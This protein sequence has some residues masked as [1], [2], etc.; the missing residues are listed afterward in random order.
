[1]A[2]AEETAELSAAFDAQER[3]LDVALE[4]SGLVNLDALA[5]D[6]V[7]AYPA[8]NDKA[9]DFNE[10]RDVAVPLNHDVTARS[11]FADA[12]VTGDLVILKD[13]PFSA[14]WA[15]DG[16]GPPPDFADLL[17]VGAYNLLSCL[18]VLI[19]GRR[20]G[21]F[22]RRWRRVESPH[23]NWLRDDRGLAIS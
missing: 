18:R 16:H 21:W 20:H 23:R 7:A 5:G 17:A 4:P 2:Y 15:E 11:E 3:G 12:V 14:M 10:R 9:A 19:G 13:E 8:L 22:H 6:D 1:M